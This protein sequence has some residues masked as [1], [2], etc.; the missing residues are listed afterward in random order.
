[1]GRKAPAAAAE[2]PAKRQRAPAKPR[3]VKPKDCLRGLSLGGSNKSESAKAADDASSQGAETEAASGALTTY[4]ASRGETSS[5]L[6][7]LKY[8][9]DPTKNKSGDNLDQAHSALML[10]KTL[11]ADEK[12]KF[13]EAF[14]LKGKKDLSWVDSFTKTTTVVDTSVEQRKTGFFNLHQILQMNGLEPHNLSPEL[15]S[16]ISDQ[17]IADSAEK[18]GY[19]RT[20]RLHPTMP[21]LSTFYYEHG[22]GTLVST[23]TQE[24]ETFQHHG[25]GQSEAVQKAMTGALA[26]LPSAAAK[27]IKL[28][29]PAFFLMQEKVRVLKSGKNALERIVMQAADLSAT[30]TSQ[31]ASDPSFSWLTP[32]QTE[33]M[34]TDR[35]IHTFLG[36]IREQLIVC[37]H[38]KKDDDCSG[39]AETIG[40]LIASAVAL[41]KKTKRTCKRTYMHTCMHTY[42]HTY[43][44]KQ[45]TQ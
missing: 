35:K 3:T 45:I 24:K 11:D 21:I 19:Q 33:L 6:S 26:A 12:H 31:I 20:E 40:A 16:Q 1:M 8:S 38:V 44:Q 43:I 39:M 5:M 7:S 17:L 30:M 9:A 41:S 32:K 23:G 22:Q 4:R 15:Q 28:E 29:N 10:Y 2:S 14:A 37:Q 13:V 34:E 36:M 42:I 25:Q 18:Y 27:E